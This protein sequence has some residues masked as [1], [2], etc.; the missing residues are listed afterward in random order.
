MVDNLITLYESDERLFQTNGLG[1]L[2]DA[3]KCEVTEELN[4][5]FEL[6]MEYPITGIH[7]EDIQLRRIIFTRVNHNPY[8]QAFRIYSIS[9]PIGGI[10]T[11]QAEH[12]SYDLSNY[13]LPPFKAESSAEAIAK[14]GM[15]PYM[16]SGSPSNPFVINSN[17]EQVKEMES[18]VPVSIRSLISGNSDSFIDIFGGEISYSSSGF[19]IDINTRRGTDRSDDICIEYG[20]NL[21]D[22]RQEANCS[23]MYT[24]ILPYFYYYNETTV[25]DQTVIEEHIEFITG[26]LIPVINLFDWEDYLNKVKEQYSNFEWTYDELGRYRVN[27]VT[28]MQQ[29]GLYSFAEEDTSVAFSI[30]MRR[31][32][33]ATTAGVKFAL[34]NEDGTKV[35]E[36]RG[37]NDDWDEDH[38]D[39]EI[40]GSACKIGLSCTRG[41]PAY[42]KWA[43]VSSNGPFV[44]IMPLDTSSDWNNKHGWSKQFPSRDEVNEIGTK[45]LA[46]N[47]LTK[48]VINIDVSFEML[49]QTTE[50]ANLSLDERVYLGDTIKVRFIK[51]GIDATSRV[52]KTVY[53]V[54]NGKFTSIEL[55]EGKSDFAY[56]MVASQKQTQ[57][58]IVNNTD[59][60]KEQFDYATKLVTG[61]VG[62]YVF[63]RDTDGDDQPDEILIMDQQN[64]NDALNVWQWNKNGMI[65]MHRANTD[66]DFQTNT[67]ITMDGWI[68]GERIA[69]HSM[70]ANSI[71]GGTLILGNRDFGSGVLDLY[72][73]S[74]TL[75]AKMSSEGLRFYGSN[76]SSL[77]S[78]NQ[79]GS[80]KAG[81]VDAENITGTIIS[82]KIVRVGGDNDE[83]GK[84]LVLDDEGNTI[85]TIDRRGIVF[86][87]GHDLQIS[88][89]SITDIPDDLAYE[90]EI[91]TADAITQISQNV[92]STATIRANQIQAG[93]INGFTI[94][95]TNITGS[96]ISGSVIQSVDTNTGYGTT[97]QN[98]FM[99][100]NF[101]DLTGN[102][103][104][105]T[106]ASIGSQRVTP[107]G[108]VIDAGSLYFYDGYIYD[109][110]GFTANGTITGDELRS[111]TS[112]TT[113]TNQPLSF[114]AG[115]V[116]GLIRKYVASSSSIRYKHDFKTKFNNDLDP[117]GILNIKII[118][119]KYKT[120]FLNDP[121]DK[122]YDKDVI[123]FIAED[124]YKKYKV[125]SDYYYDKKR[126]KDIITGWSPYFMIPPM[127]YLIQEQHEEIE[128][129]K[130]EV[131]ELKAQMSEILKIL[132][133][134]E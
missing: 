55:G 18:K 30:A 70:S 56:H 110:E 113:S 71:A 109:T 76:G 24:H 105:S 103:L 83:D 99:S 25:E 68:R 126:E 124:V 54:L 41:G 13:I 80:I 51:M 63:L 48:P 134:S 77:V 116:P 44:K 107:Q 78:I 121:E 23:N 15:L 128:N 21:T 14:L 27:D 96:N 94:T 53:N 102:I 20:K 114:T 122:L 85:I 93:T 61:N 115:D 33:A 120:D 79:N 28:Y 29:Y 10:V 42:F 39:K 8:R 26:Y 89:G 9:K 130:Q 67:A 92:V 38:G 95:G 60:L 7:Y 58:E 87:E 125:A 75:I 86:A 90:D 16:P 2:S 74:G 133:P 131:S 45:Y 3:S 119:F 31:D 50:F 123:G 47:D 73:S 57:A 97:I 104:A 34:Y 4:G 62:G 129:L 65:H 112:T 111:L 81:S 36:T 127:L 6:E 52:V 98:G 11:I 101:M 49:S 37:F 100:T 12:I 22:I 84:I 59:W 19:R 46:D 40:S 72:N 118:Q 88:W 35:A 64:Y 82:G 91:P 66:V 5:A 43:Y 117:H 17:I 132:K 106:G 1:N 32:T 69:A 108:G